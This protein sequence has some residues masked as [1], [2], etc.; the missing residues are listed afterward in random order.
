VF[1]IDSPLKAPHSMKVP[2]FFKKKNNY[3]TCQREV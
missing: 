2:F 3:S 1:E